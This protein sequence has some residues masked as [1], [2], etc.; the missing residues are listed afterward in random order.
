MR[1]LLL[2]V[3]LLG[4]GL[5]HAAQ[6]CPTLVSQSPYITHTLEWMGLKHCIIGTSR[7]EDLGLSQT[8][9]VLDPDAET[10]ALLHPDILLS[11]DWITEEKARAI[12]PSG[13]RVYRLHGFQAMSQIEDNLTTIADAMDLQEPN[14][15]AERFHKLWRKRLTQLHGG[16]TKVLLLSACSGNPYS[17]G[18]N[19]WLYD[20]F[21][22]AG[23]QVV[24]NHDN[25]RLMEPDKLGEL[26]DRLQ[27]ELVFVFESKA[28]RQCRLITPR[29]PVQII[30]L[31][32]EKLLE[33]SPALLDGLDKLISKQ[34]AWNP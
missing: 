19:T 4:G 12:T 28:A 21:T 20:L 18:K 17:F 5:A 16:N 26:I 25:I 13:S 11:S 7:Y 32:G 34:S 2:A 1:S 33:P 31:D 29:T 23:F 15:F 3:L 6:D 30:T 9:G 10:I 22:Q 27:P 24:E 8:G 14:A